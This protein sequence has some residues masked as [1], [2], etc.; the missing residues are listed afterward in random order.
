MAASSYSWQNKTTGTPL[1]GKGW[2][3]VAV[4]SS[5][6]YM[7]AIVYGGDIYASSNF[8]TT[9]TDE[10]PSGAQHNKS[11]SSLGMSAT[12]QYS[13]ATID[14]G[15]TYVSSDYGVTWVDATSGGAPQGFWQ[16]QA[17]AV[18]ATGQYQV[19]TPDSGNT[20][21][22]MSSDY[23]STWANKT[24]SGVAHGLTASSVAIS[25]DAQYI[26]AVADSN[27][28]G[29][30]FTSN[31]RGTTWTDRSAA[32]TRHWQAVTASL[33]GQYMVAV[34]DGGD[35]YTSSNYGVTWAD[36]SASGPA[37]NLLWASISS[38]ASGQYVTAMDD[39]G[40]HIFT[41]SDYG[42]TWTNV[43]PAGLGSAIEVTIASNST[44]QYLVTGIGG[45]DIFVGQDPSLAVNSASLNSG[46]IIINTPTGA[47]ITCSS[48]TSETSLSKQDSSYSYPLGLVNLCFTTQNSNNQVTVTF[49]TNLQPSQV[50]ARDFNTNTGA[51][52]NIP[53]AVITQTS[54]NG[55]PALNLTYTIT[56]NG[57]LDTNSA[58]YSVSDPVGLA[59]INTNVIAPNT[60]YGI[61]DTPTTHTN[62][63]FITGL[64]SLGTGLYLSS[65]RQKARSKS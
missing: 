28:G 14:N 13:V 58:L 10:T 61:P 24:P 31:D 8:G 62:L 60:G 6:Q 56:D 22:Y 16:P 23:G 29:D 12:G 2:S 52:T 41:S 5:G 54:Y 44:G 15:H 32:G 38:S 39:Y 21:V 4:S 11:W 19:T 65:R 18:S 45:G 47:N 48:T 33:S 1:N 3:R 50:V 51:Y 40:T 7:G 59:A 25:S 35:I 20:D 43:T 46:T 63:I 53:G 30:I 37:H 27:S 17:T 64:I 34:D 42:A 49:V 55:Q 36:S 26:V 57:T 9:W